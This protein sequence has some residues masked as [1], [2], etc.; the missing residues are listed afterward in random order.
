MLINSAVSF[1]LGI[2]NEE[3]IICFFA[4]S[5]NRYLIYISQFDALLLIQF[6]KTIHFEMFMTHCQMLGKV[7][8]VLPAK[9]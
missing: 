8:S 6:G 4:T 5:F 1:G 7:E 2:R 9:I 3:F